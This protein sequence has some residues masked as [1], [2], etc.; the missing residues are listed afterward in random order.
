MNIKLIT[1]P[2]L[3]TLSNLMCG[4][5]SIA[6]SLL[7]G[8]LR[9]AA[10]LI[11]L[12]A[13]FDFFDG[14]AARLL[15]CPSAI[16]V[17][18]DS[19]ADMVS[20]GVAPAFAMFVLYGQSPSAFGLDDTLL[21]AG[22]YMLLLSAA[23]AALRLAKFNIDESQHEEFA[24]L[25]TT[26]D[27]IFCASLCYCCVSGGTVLAKEWIFAI[28]AVASVLMISPIRMFS[29]K[30]KSFGWRGNEVRYAFLVVAAALLLWL[31]IYAIPLIIVIYVVVS[32]VLWVIRS[33]R[34]Q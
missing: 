18:L 5:A 14:F 28:V 34:S 7:Y 9:L 3:L 23:F 29:F 32:T 20:F 31:R 33:R 25:T 17:Q 12:A 21:E 10:A 30:M 16:G 1:I 2:N 27:A 6:V 15:K 11:V 24:G 4:T 26:A 22:R 13:V 19:L 8:E